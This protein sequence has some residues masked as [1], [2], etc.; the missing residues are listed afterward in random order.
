MGSDLVS[1]C[2][3][4]AG[5]LLGTDLTPWPG[6]SAEAA[7]SYATSAKPIFKRLS[8]IRNKINRQAS[9]LVMNYF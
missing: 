7:F 8:L 6:Y 2:V 5:L 4:C 9:S 1:A 3:F